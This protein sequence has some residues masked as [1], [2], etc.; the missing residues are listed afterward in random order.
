MSVNRANEAL[1]DSG[2][3]RLAKQAA[4]LWKIQCSTESLGPR[5]AGGE[6]PELC[7]LG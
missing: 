7:L 5:Q 2:Y 6:G 4:S 3:R 1:S